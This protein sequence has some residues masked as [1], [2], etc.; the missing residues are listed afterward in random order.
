MKKYIGLLGILILAL[1]ACN[2]ESNAAIITNTPINQIGTLTSIPI[3]V[4]PTETHIPQAATLSESGKSTVEFPLPMLRQEQIQEVADCKIEELASTRYPEDVDSA[5]LAKS[6][7]PESNCDW[8]ILAYS[9]AV[10][11]DNESPSLLGLDAFE[12]ATV[13]NYGFALSSLFAYYFGSVPLVTIPDFADQEIEKVEINYTWTG[14]GE[15]SKIEHSVM[16]DHANANP[17]ISSRTDSISSNITV[18]KAVIQDLKNGLN[19]LLPIDSEIQL[20]YCFDNYPEWLVTLTFDDGTKIDMKSNSN[21]LFI[22]GPWQTEIDE[23]I[24]LQYSPAFAIKMGNLVKSIK[25]P[26]GEPAA[27]SCFGGVVFENAF[28]RFLPSTPTPRPNFTLEAIRTAVAQTVEV[29]LTQMA[30]ETPTP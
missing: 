21:F 20:I 3:T 5:D 13:G 22:G 7:T 17:I 4:F 28:G 29:Q 27:M 11:N 26:L 6:F 2:R 1:S 14:L 8:A 9:Y 12:K 15:P 24:Y 30:A 16:I 18:D 19:D 23:Q 25:L 10:R